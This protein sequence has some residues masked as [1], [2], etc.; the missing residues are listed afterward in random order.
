[1]TFSRL[2]PVLLTVALAA[3]T[4]PV[5]AQQKLLP[6]QSSIAFEIKQMGVPVQG[7]FK[8]FD[9]QINF[10]AAKLATSKVTFTVDIASTTLGAPEMDSELPKATWFNT[11]KFP[12]AQFTSS[13][14]KALG[15][16]KYE[17]AGKLAIKGQ[18][19]DVT[20]PL[21]MTQN[22]ATT[23]A[24]GVLPI[25]RLAFKIGEGDWADTSMVADDVQVRFTLAL[26]GI[27]KLPS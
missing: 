24:S 27:P 12:Q 17:V 26:S 15:G 10:D 2:T 20:V 18:S 16:G 9:A 8:K 3:A 6:A 21:A 19:R 14:F 13:A 1:M 7:H 5:A 22:G 11:A 23:T 25:K 4:L